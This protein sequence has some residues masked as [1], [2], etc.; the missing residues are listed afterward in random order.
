MGAYDFGIKWNI[1]RRLTLPTCD[2]RV[3]PASAP[4]TTCVRGARWDLSQQW[5]GRSAA[6]DYPIENTRALLEAGRAHL[7]DLSGPP[8]HGS[9]D[10]R[11]YLRA[12]FGHRGANHPVKY[13][14]HG[15]VEITSQNHGVAVD[16]ESLPSDVQVTHLNLYDGTVEGLRHV[17]RPIFSVSII[18]RRRQDLTTPTTCS[19]SLRGEERTRR[20]GRLPSRLW[21]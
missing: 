12:S 17:S 19:G 2:V 11:Q 6:L 4:A 16:P 14:G 9:G 5:S 10:G 21:Q 15:A 13:T 3:F 18:L 8:D 7:R 20:L 1:L